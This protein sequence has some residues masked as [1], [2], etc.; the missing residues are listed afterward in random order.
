MQNNACSGAHEDARM[1]RRA[2]RGAVKRENDRARAKEIAQAKSRA[3]A[4][5]Q[6]NKKKNEK[7]TQLWLS[8]LF[9][10]KEKYLQ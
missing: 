10:G 7:K 9:K 1:K 8:R 4:K 6:H 5:T 2:C 3:R